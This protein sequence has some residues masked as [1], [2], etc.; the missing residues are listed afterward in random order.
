MKAMRAIIPASIAF[1]LAACAASTE[2]AGTPDF[3]YA[4]RQGCDSGY[5]FANRPRH[6]FHYRRDETRFQA[7]AEYR[8]GW[9][10]G[11]VACY[12]EEIRFPHFDSGN[13]VR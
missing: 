12:E 3:Q 11:F 2:P 8:E 7:D 9:Q 4:Y 1:M 13:T 6:E 10:K 5:S